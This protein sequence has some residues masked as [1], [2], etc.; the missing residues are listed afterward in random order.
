MQERS[1]EHSVSSDVSSARAHLALINVVRT[2]LL[3]DLALD[4]VTN[5]ALRHHGNSD[6]RLD[7]LDHLRVRHASNTTVL[8]DVRRDA[9]ERHHSAGT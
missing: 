3:Q 9:L 7:L 8:A 6:S 2:N 4:K 5:P 1:Q